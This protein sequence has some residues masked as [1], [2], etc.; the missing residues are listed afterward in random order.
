MRGRDYLIRK[1]L[2]LALH[3]RSVE[4]I[5]TGDVVISGGLSEYRPGEDTSFHPVFERADSLMYEEKK[6][7]KGMGA[8]TR[9]DAELAAKPAFRDDENA[10]ILHLK[11]HILIVED[12]RIN[13][14]MRIRRALCLRRHRGAGADQAQR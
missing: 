12:E 9:E 4:H 2:V 13:Q 3:D 5:S 8:V 10:D 1:E 11:H 14:M 7:L 6:L